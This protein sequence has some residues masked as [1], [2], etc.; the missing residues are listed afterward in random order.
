MKQITHTHKHALAHPH[1]VRAMY[2][3]IVCISS[4]FALGALVEV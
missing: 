3:R 4:C 1:T 2:V